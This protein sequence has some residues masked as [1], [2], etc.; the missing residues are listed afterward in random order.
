ML[1]WRIFS[2]DGLL[3]LDSLKPGTFR[4]YSPHRSD[5]W[6]QERESYEALS[7]ELSQLD[8]K[9]GFLFYGYSV[10]TLSDPLP[11]FISLSEADTLIKGTGSA[12]LLFDVGHKVY[13]TYNKSRIVSYLMNRLS[14][15]PDTLIRNIL[16]VQAVQCLHFK[17]NLLYAAELF[18]PYLGLSDGKA[19]A[20][21]TLLKSYKE[22][23]RIGKEKLLAD[24]KANLGVLR[25]AE[26]YEYAG[27]RYREQGQQAPDAQGAS[28]S[29]FLFPLYTFCLI[30]AHALSTGGAATRF[31]QS[32][33]IS[34]TVAELMLASSESTRRCVST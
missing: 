7:V 32:R 4:Q 19:I 22:V 6:F 34:D 26:A 21:D 14:I 13:Y 20:P 18:R 5:E 8:G 10:D 31:T 1:H 25:N 3:L 29:A 28:L 16:S 33:S 2:S 17:S 30:P 9:T 27:P 24:K 11:F 23:Y 12:D 15:Q